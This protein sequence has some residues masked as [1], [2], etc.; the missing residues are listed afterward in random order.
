MSKDGFSYTSNEI[1][2]NDEDFDYELLDCYP[3]YSYLDNLFYA[4]ECNDYLEIEDS[5]DDNLL[6]YTSTQLEEEG[7]EMS[8]SELK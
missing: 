6:W 5:E 2:V 3:G 4:I 7:G 1:D 8:I